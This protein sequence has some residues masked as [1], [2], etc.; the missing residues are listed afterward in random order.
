MRLLSHLRRREQLT[1]HLPEDPL[2]HEGVQRRKWHG[3]QAHEH[4]REGHVHDEQ[5]GGAVHG[6]VAEDDEHHEDVADHADDED[7]E[8]QQAEGDAYPEVVDQKLLVAVGGVD[9]RGVVDHRVVQSAVFNE[10]HL[11]GKEAFFSLGLERKQLEPWLEQTT[12]SSGEENNLNW[13][14]LLP[15]WLL[16]ILVCTNLIQVSAAAVFI[17]SPAKF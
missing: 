12:K 9:G 15:K 3:K 16:C 6:L 1:K 4:V 2:V 5:V 17:L 7:D 14:L 8:V 11:G 10:A 13:S